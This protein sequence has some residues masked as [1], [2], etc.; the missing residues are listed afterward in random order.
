MTRD[1]ASEALSPVRILR[2]ITRLNVGG[3]SIQAIEL[4][5]RMNTRGYRTRLVFGQLVVVTKGLEQR[6]KV[7]A[8]LEHALATEFPSAVA[9]VYPL[10]LG[11]P[12]GWPL[13]YRV[14][15]PE[16][17]KVRAIAFQVAQVL[18]ADPAPRNVNYNWMQPAR[19]LRI[20]VDQDKARILGLS[21]Q[22]LATSLNAVVSGLTA[23]QVRSGI[24][25]VDVL[26]RAN[27]E[28]R[29][30]LSTIR[31]LQVPLSSGKTVPLSDIASIDYGQMRDSVSACWKISGK[32]RKLTW[33]IKSV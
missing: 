8:R 6:E 13:Q 33:Q 4:S 2:V 28:Q 10:E 23:T 3:P 9:R 22:E 14:R 18:G 27:G 25:L 1:A 16:P 5:S 17:D 15:G 19:M 26:V 11:P 30:D 32:P 31:A 12:V 7:K 21:S 20:Q 29:M 24:H